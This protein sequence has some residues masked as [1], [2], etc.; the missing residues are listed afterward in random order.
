M[1]MIA[2]QQRGIHVECFHFGSQSEGT[3]IPGLQ[4]D[5]DVL[6]S[7][8]KANIM[9]VWGDWKAGMVNLLMLNDDM[10]PQ[11]LLQVIRKY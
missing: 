8:I 3:T 7:N 6:F 2:A 5:I 1:E 9:R 11:Y 10:I 4:S